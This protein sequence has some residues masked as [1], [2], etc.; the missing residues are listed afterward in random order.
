MLAP[1]RRCRHISLN[2]GDDGDGDEVLHFD[3]GHQKAF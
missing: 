1:N 2:G 3:C